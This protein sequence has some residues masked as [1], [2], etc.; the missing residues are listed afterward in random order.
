LKY[1]NPIFFR[2][3]IRMPNC[4]GITQRGAACTR[5]GRVSFEGHYCITHFEMKM[6][7]DIGFRTRR[8]AQI[9]AER[10]EQE[11]RL[12]QRAAQEAQRVAQ[13]AARMVALQAQNVAQQAEHD[14]RQARKREQKRLKNTRLI[15]EA[16]L[17]SPDTII[18]Y[19]K[20]LMRMWVPANDQRLDFPKAYAFLSYR[21]STHEGFPALIRATTTIVRQGL[22]HHPIHATYGE[23]P[24]EEREPP[25]QAL[26][27]ALEPYGNITNEVLLTT[28]DT[29]DPYRNIIRNHIREAEARAARE[30]AQV[31]LQH[32]LQH[33][34]VVFQRDPE[35]SINLQAFGTD[36]ENVHR[37]S[38]HNTTHIVALALLNR[39]LLPNQDTL[40]EVI[41][42]FNRPGYVL[43]HNQRSR[44]LAV[45]EITNDY[46]NTEAF[47]L[48]YGDVLDHVWA[49][50]KVHTEKKELVLRLAQ[51]VCDGIQKCTNGKMARLINVLQGF[52]ETLEYEKPK[53]LF[54]GRFA[55]LTTL[56]VND[57]THAANELFQE[58]Q[59]PEEQRQDW[60]N[61]LLEAE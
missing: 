6:R 10:V 57:R 18:R 38:V 32:D 31:Q 8:N 3:P 49:Y 45:N 37:S 25:L 33:N 44:E 48:K 29:T 23:V 28:I 59:I 34:P 30:A 11:V 50:I 43:W 16:H 12:A 1:K 36:R 53:E 9:E 19:A 24:L 52:D 14:A 41:E 27:L 2:N 35:G 39:P 40:P 47:S 42:D 56:P 58:F 22:G 54:Q 55:R 17:F 20:Y 15:Q 61:S 21:T 13:E 26:R 7:D 60:L 4:I 5:W 51:E 46:F